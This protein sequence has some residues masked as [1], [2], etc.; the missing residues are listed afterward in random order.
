MNIPRIAYAQI[1]NDY[2]SKEALNNVISAKDFVDFT[3]VVHDG[4]RDEIKEQLIRAG[5]HLAQF[6]FQ[7]N[8]PE[9]RNKYLDIARELGADYLLFG[10]TDEHFDSVFLASI[11]SIIMSCPMY[12]GFEV[13]AHYDITNV[14]VMDPNEISREAPAG[15]GDKTNWWK[16]A[17]IRLEPDMYHTGHGARKNTHEILVS[18]DWRIV[19]LP[20]RYFFTQVKTAQNIWRNC[21]RQIVISGG[22]IGVGT[23][24]KF[25]NELSPILQEL[26]LSDWTAFEKYCIKGN[27][28]S[29]LKKLFIDNK[30]ASINR[31]D[32]EVRSMFKWYFTDLHPEENVDHL[33]SNFVPSKYIDGVHD[34]VR[35]AYFI[36]LGRDVDLPGLNNYKKMINEGNLQS[37]RLVDALMASEEFVRNLINTSFIDVLGRQPAAP[38][39]NTWYTLITRN[40]VEPK[41]LITGLIEQVREMSKLKIAYCQMTYK[42]DVDK[43]IQNVKAA[44]EYVDWCIVVYDDTL[45][46]DQ[47]QAL[48]DAGARARYYKWED[49]FPQQ[50][51]NYL[52]E[53]WYVGAHW[54]MVSDPD[55]HFDE[56][57]LKK[58]REVCLDANRRGA[59]LLMV[60]VHDIYTDDEKGNPLETPIELV[61]DYKK[62]LMYALKPDVSYYGV[63]VKKNLHEGMTGQFV[64]LDLGPEYFYRHTKSHLEVWEHA[65][66]NMFIGGGGDNLGEKNPTYVELKAITDRLGY[67]EWKNFRQ[68]LVDG[69]VDPKLIHFM[70]NHRSDYEHPWDS[71]SREFFK[72]YFYILHRDE[73]EAAGCPE[74]APEPEKHVDEVVQ[75]VKDAYIKALGRE[76]DNSGR[77]YYTNE[78]KSGRLSKDV[79]QQTLMA[80]E[81]YRK[82]LIAQN[83]PEL[84][85]QHSK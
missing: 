60:P 51:N 84:I 55:E 63:G 22:G 67:N 12:N 45:S 85:Q 10:D 75:F 5:T 33:E 73:W 6:D 25:Y 50:R 54:I 27:I 72:W 56:V 3:I 61:P 30:D 69:N 81:E 68:Y 43:A 14:N 40:V 41:M 39:Y 42:G 47:I 28:D 65:A 59:T 83:T 31:W 48:H 71:E 24:N 17:L 77:D 34:F 16:L 23:E 66:R 18:A 70:I 74:V 38:E 4:I 58:A 32:S 20:K 78:I 64:R 21:A 37:A 46:R 44:K 49:N 7:D 62:N 2:W 26:G 8:F 11:K 79:L 80:S 9:F 52:I 29:R 82:R 35:R 36:A 1:T 13:Y 76:P 57:L 53:S 15:L 19:K